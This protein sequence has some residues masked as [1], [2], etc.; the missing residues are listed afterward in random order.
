MQKKSD[1]F[2][3]FSMEQAA[4]LSQSKA[5]QQLFALLQRNHGEAL[6]TAM[7]QASAG[8][9]AKVKET[10]QQLMASP[11]AQELLKKLQE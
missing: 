7:Q 10:M 4:A 2:Q 6:Q 1:G 11:Q 3:N 9:Y 8:D 5:A